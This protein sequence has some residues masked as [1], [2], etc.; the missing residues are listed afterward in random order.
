MKQYRLI[1]ASQHTRVNHRPAQADG[2]REKA[3]HFHAKV[4]E[5]YIPSVNDFSCEVIDQ[6]W[7]TREEFFNITQRCI[8]EILMIEKGTRLK[9]KKYCARG[10]ETS[11][12][13]AIQ[14]KK[15]NRRVAYDAVLDLQQEELCD[16]E[17]IRETYYDASVSCQMW[18]HVVGMQDQREAELIYEEDEEQAC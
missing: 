7:F 16:G 9:G 3:V 13:L 6:C 11:T 18:A 14:A 15:Q 10:L 2:G 8:K 17:G 5:C 1:V 12:R 4:S